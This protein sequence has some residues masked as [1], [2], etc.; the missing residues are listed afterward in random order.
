MKQTQLF[1]L[2]FCGLLLGLVGCTPGGGEADL[3]YLPVIVD[4]G[5][6]WGMIG[7]DGKILFNDE[8]ENEPSSVVNGVFY[9]MENNRYSLYKAKEK[10]ELIKG[11]EDLIQPGYYTEGLIPIV[12]EGERISLINID[13][14][15]KLTLTPI[16]GQEV[17]QSGNRFEEGNLHVKLQNGKYGT[18]NKKGEVIIEPKY[19]LISN[20]S[21][22]ICVA[23]V[24]GKDS[25]DSI[26][27]VCLNNNGKEIFKIKGAYKLNNQAM[28]MGFQGGRFPVIKGD[29]LGFIDRKGEFNKI[30][31]KY[32]EYIP[33][34]NKYFAVKN[35]DDKWG[36]LDRDNEVV[37]RLKYSDV[38][39]LGE[40][41]FYVRNEKNSEIINAKGD[42]KAD[43]DEDY[44][45]FAFSLLS[46]LGF[47]NSFCLAGGENNSI[48]LYGRDGKPLTK[49]D[50]YKLGVNILQDSYADIRSDFFDTAGIARYIANAISVEGFEK[51]KLGNAITDY[52][53][54]KKPE[55]FADKYSLSFDMEKFKFMNA[56]ANL[57]VCPYGVPIVF[58]EPVYSYE[59]YYGYTYQSLSGY[60]YSWNPASKVGSIDLTINATRPFYKQCKNQ[61]IEL[62]K[63]KGFTVEGGGEDNLSCLLKN[64]KTYVEIRPHRGTDAYEEDDESMSQLTIDVMSENYYQY[65]IDTAP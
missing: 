54:G 62:L 15:T 3:E 34:S 11:A 47:A 65:K 29:I 32:T 53:K 43:I 17:I 51:I 52:L 13:G 31:S 25:D 37:L 56:S 24:N 40:D 4:K 1:N 10:P 48:M 5:D 50:F 12:R 19:D 38:E 41:L 14:E 20:F 39:Y 61:L 59:N 7:P 28:A 16:S 57:E 22:G 36:I 46:R 27:I 33:L 18:I 9:V 64:G 58:S 26:T 35:S 63:N 55:D 49:S 45:L 42:I 21:E 44:G 30:P 60:N 8:F 6:K 23:I 2:L